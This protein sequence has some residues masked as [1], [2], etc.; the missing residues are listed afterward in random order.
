MS[1]NPPN[2]KRTPENAPAELT[3]SEHGHPV[4]DA[5]TCCSTRVL[6]CWL[7]STLLEVAHPLECEQGNPVSLLKGH[8]NTPT[9]HASLWRTFFPHSHLTWEGRSA[10]PQYLTSSARGKPRPLYTISPNIRVAVWEIQV[11]LGV[12][13]G[14]FPLLCHENGVHTSCLQWNTESGTKAL[15]DVSSEHS[16]HVL[17]PAVCGDNSQAVG[18]VCWLDNCKLIHLMMLC[19]SWA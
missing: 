9:W 17:D 14:I 2:P 8:S 12:A 4:P 18:Q 6:Q 5:G 7:H 11:L 3:N 1:P 19:D 10:S 13:H 16:S 15:N